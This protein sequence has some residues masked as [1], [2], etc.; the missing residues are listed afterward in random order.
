MRPSFVGAI[1]IAL[2]ACVAHGAEPQRFRLGVP[3]L[4]QIDACLDREAAIELARASAAG[5]QERARAVASLLAAEGRCGLVRGTLV[6]HRQLFRQDARD[7]VFTVY[8]ASIGAIR[9]YIPLAGYLH[10][11]I[12]I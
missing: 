3:V 9:I 7:T 4:E 10:E 2:I 8:E 12:D 1:A 11:G 5:D 6:Y